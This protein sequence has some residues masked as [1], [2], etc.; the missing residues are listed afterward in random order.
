MARGLFE[1][2]G[3]KYLATDSGDLLSSGVH[4]YDDE[5]YAVN[6]DGSVQVESTVQVDTD[7]HGRL[8]TLR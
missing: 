3:V 1:V 2:D 8:T 7:T 5:A 4:V 6:A